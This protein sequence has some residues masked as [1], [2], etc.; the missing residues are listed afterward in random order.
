MPT[1][2]FRCQEC[3]HKFT[4]MVSISEKDKVKCPNCGSGKVQQ[5]MTGFFTKGS[6]CDHN[7]AGGG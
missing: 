6:A 5:L 7:Y 4:V 3:D 2:D 1:Y